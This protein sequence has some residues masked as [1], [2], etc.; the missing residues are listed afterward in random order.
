MAEQPDMHAEGGI[1]ALICMPGCGM[2][3][4]DVPE[5]HIRQLVA[6]LKATACTFC[7]NETITGLF[8]WMRVDL[9]VFRFGGG[10]GQD[11]KHTLY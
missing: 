10:T 1:A 9:G 4:V 8:V 3:I 11:T 2:L 7:S 5:R 6:L